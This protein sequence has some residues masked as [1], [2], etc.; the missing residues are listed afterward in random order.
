MSL[1]LDRLEAARAKVAARFVDRVRL[2]VDPER[3]DDDTWDEATLTATPPPEDPTQAWPD[4]E[5][6]DAVGYALIAP[7][8]IGQGAET[9]TEA[10]ALRYRVAVPHDAVV[11]RPGQWYEVLEARLN[12]DLVGKTFTVINVEH[13]SLTPYLLVK[14][15]LATNVER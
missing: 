14:A 9:D 12:P 2:L 8:T 7:D 4:P 1:A 13:S 15:V 5:D 11:P 10:R 6:P 3:G